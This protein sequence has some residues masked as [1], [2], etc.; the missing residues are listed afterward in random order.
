[1]RLSFSAEGFLISA[2]ETQYFKS[3]T[4]SARNKNGYS[5]SCSSVIAGVAVHQ[6]EGAG[7]KEAIAAGH[8]FGEEALS[9]TS[10]KLV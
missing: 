9:G 7:V 3:R 2:P 8:S 6:S 1:M 10:M 5:P 4:R